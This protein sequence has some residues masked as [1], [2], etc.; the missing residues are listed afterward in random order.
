MLK[1]DLNSASRNKNTPCMAWLNN[2]A[3]CKV[4][5]SEVRWKKFLGV[6]KYNVQNQ[7]IWNS[8]NAHYRFIDNLYIYIAIFVADLHCK[9]MSYLSYGKVHVILLFIL[10]WNDVSSSICNVYNLT[11]CNRSSIPQSIFTYY[12]ALQRAC[13]YNSCYQFEF[14]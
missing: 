9:L 1:L 14:W 6:I 13:H 7:R 11:L 8:R 3:Y 10:I 5:S 12:V 4:F 2:L